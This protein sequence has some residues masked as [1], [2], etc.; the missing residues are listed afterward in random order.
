MTTPKISCSLMLLEG[1]GLHAVF[2][3]PLKTCSEMQNLVQSKN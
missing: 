3:L 2:A 1:L